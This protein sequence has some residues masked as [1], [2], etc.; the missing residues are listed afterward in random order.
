[1]LSLNAMSKTSA[2]IMGFVAVVVVGFFVVVVVLYS[3]K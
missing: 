1:M 3:Q 2:S